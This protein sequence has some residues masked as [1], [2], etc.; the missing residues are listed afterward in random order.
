[1]NSYRNNKSQITVFCDASCDAS[2]NSIGLGVIVVGMSKHIAVSELKQVAAS[3][4]LFGEL[5]A[6]EFSIKSLSELLESNTFA[7]DN[8]ERAIIYSDCDIIKRLLSK[9]LLSK[10]VY[11]ELIDEIINLLQKLTSTYKNTAF[12]V[13]YIGA[14]RKF[15]YYKAAHAAARKV[16][17]KE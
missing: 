9:T 11:T 15:A 3:D 8:L 4:P 12:S 14:R 7:V 13:K 16:L 6:I 10:S 2:N 17:G 1:M 5:L